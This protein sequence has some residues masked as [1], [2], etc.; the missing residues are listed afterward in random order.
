[1]RRRRRLPSSE[2]PAELGPGSAT[3]VIGAH[4]LEEELEPVVETEEAV[5]PVEESDELVI[6]RLGLA[7]PLG[8]SPSESGGGSDG[9]SGGGKPS[10][11]GM[12]PPSPPEHSIASTQ[13]VPTHT[14]SP[15][16]QKG[17]MTMVGCPL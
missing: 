5:E 12:V 15:Q 6:D 3:V 1:M 7:E 10:M 2:S 8:E 11:P 4:S 16:V 9:G 17:A 13:P 14:G